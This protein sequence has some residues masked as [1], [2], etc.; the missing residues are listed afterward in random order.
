MKKILIVLLSL[1]LLSGCSQK[2][3]TTQELVDNLTKLSDE[4][5]AYAEVSKTKQIEKLVKDNCEIKIL[6]DKKDSVVLEVTS[7]NLK[8]WLSDYM[9]YNY[10]VFE[11]D[12]IFMDISADIFYDNMIMAFE[13]NYLSPVSTTVEVPIEKVDKEKRLVVTEDLIDAIYGGLYSY[14]IEMAG[15]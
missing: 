10:D 2:G 12:V 8:E 9:M 11:Y 13:N 6:E 3:P 7:L 15:E 5:I 14:I 1:S 4:E